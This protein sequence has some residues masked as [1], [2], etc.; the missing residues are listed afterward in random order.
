MLVSIL[1]PTFNR[2]DY[3]EEAVNSALNQD[4]EHIEVIIVDNASTDSSWEKIINLSHKSERIKIFQNKENIG[5]VKNWK[6]CLDLSSGELIKF[7]FSDDLLH[8]NCIS[9]LTNEL[10]ED[11]GFVFSPVEIFSDETKKREIRYQLPDSYS[12]N[13]ENFIKD[14]IFSDNFPVSPG[15]AIFRRGDVYKNLHLDIPNNINSDFSHHGIGADL[16]L[17]L[18]TARSY[19]FYGYIDKPLS[20]FRSNESSISEVSGRSKRV[21][22]YSLVKSFYIEHFD[23]HLKK[24]FASY[25][26]ILILYFSK[27]D[28]GEKT[29]L[30]HFFTTIPKTDLRDYLYSL[31]LISKRV[32]R[33][34]YRK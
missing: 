25:L 30:E 16:L 5:P 1:I 18:L 9:E 8:P 7:L 19:S 24:L 2:E 10:K 28:F 34:I 29:R 15:C 26:R 31:Y 33:T 20:L 3:I 27:W 14:S 32:I 11:V 21:L 13:S 12:R 4:Y 22:Y 6:K 17:F 23:K